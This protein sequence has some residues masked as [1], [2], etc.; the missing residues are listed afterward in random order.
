MNPTSAPTP[1]K[2]KQ[3]NSAVV[4]ARLLH[5]E[6]FSDY[7]ANQVES[8]WRR[9]SGLTEIQKRGIEKLDKGIAR[10]TAGMSEKD[11]Q[12]LGKFIGLHKHMSFDTGLRIGLTAHAVKR[13]KAVPNE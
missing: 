7:V 4:V 9:N 13:A 10:I 2:H 5:A 11:K 12:I 3:I 1:K 6:G 8:Y